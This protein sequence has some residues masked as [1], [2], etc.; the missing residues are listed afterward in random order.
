[1]LPDRREV[2]PA[3]RIVFSHVHI[4][5]TSGNCLIGLEITPTHK[6]QQLIVNMQLSETYDLSPQAIRV[7]IVLSGQRE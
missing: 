4:P 1:M 2:T 5:D 7:I 3:E 6:Q